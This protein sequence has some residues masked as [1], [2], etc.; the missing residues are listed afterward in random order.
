MTRLFWEESPRGR[1]YGQVL[2]RHPAG[3]RTVVRVLWDDGR[4]GSFIEGAEPK[5]LHIAGQAVQ[6]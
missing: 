5:E 4:V 2:D 3:C 1:L 6:K